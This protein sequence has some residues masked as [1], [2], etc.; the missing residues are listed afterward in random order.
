MHDKMYMWI[1]H[2]L[3]TRT[4]GVKLDGNLSTKVCCHEAAPQGCV[5]SPILFLVYTNHILTITKEVYNTLHIDD[6]AIWNVSE[7]TTT[8]TY[9]IQEVNSGVNKWTLDWDVEINIGKTNST[10]SPLS[11]S[12]EQN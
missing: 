5:L 9:R 2:F 10:L 1:Q 6:L 8:A 3:Q 11:T 12:K 7:H 4:A